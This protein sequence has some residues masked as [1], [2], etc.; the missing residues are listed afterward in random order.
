METRVKF[1]KISWLKFLVLAMQCAVLECWTEQ[2]SETIAS[3]AF[4]SAHSSVVFFLFAIKLSKIML[5][6][7]LS[8]N[9]A[10]G[11]FQFNLQNRVY[12]VYSS[13]IES[14]EAFEAYCVYFPSLT[15]RAACQLRL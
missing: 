6:L 10:K 4:K 9:Y 14:F 3:S 15:M 1:A 8:K 7:Q 13:L 5:R 11:V 12:V 2:G